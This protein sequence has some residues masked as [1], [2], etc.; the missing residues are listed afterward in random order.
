M[1]EAVALHLR[2]LELERGVSAHTLR[3]YSA[4][5]GTVVDFAEQ[6]GVA[7]DRELWDL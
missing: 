5:L 2:A 1:R 4:D 6:R 7:D 3:A